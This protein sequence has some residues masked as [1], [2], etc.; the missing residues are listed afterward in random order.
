[1][2][3]IKQVK[4]SWQTAKKNNAGH[5]DLKSNRQW[6]STEHVSNNG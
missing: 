1:M 4:T 2:N 3:H 6:K 5:D